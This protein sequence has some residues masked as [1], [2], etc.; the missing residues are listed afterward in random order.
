LG[1]H[2]HTDVFIGEDEDHLQ[3]SGHLV[4]GKDEWLLFGAVLLA[5]VAATKSAAIIQL[6]DSE[7]MIQAFI[8][9]DKNAGYTNA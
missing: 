3:L 6:P 7:A 2:C 1:K 5:G 8:D 9:Q 4:M